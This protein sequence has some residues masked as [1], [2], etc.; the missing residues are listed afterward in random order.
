M[1]RRCGG[2]VSGVREVWLV[3]SRGHSRLHRIQACIIECE[4][5][6][7]R[8]CKLCAAKQLPELSHTHNFLEDNGTRQPANQ[9]THPLY[10]LA[11][12]DSNL[13]NYVG[14]H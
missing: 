7:S 14:T 13:L 9:I 4:G 2:D 6:V 12:L 10:P 8:V 1:C 11:T 3:V 5:R